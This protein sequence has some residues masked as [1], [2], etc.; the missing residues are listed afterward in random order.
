MKFYS[1]LLPKSLISIVLLGCCPLSS[2]M[3]FVEVAEEGV[4]DGI[5][6]SLLI[7]WREFPIPPILMPKKK[8]RI[9]KKI[10]LNTKNVNT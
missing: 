1:V 2:S 7:N 9:N 6:P 10:L 5:I 8:H 4:D 3:W